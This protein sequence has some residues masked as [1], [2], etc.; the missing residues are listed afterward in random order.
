MCPLTVANILS[1]STYPSRIRIAIVQQNSPS[2][3]DVDCSLP[4]STTC[5][6]SP[7]HVLCRHAHQVDL[8]PMDASTA[9]GPV[10]ARAVGSRLYHGEAYA[11]Q[12][13]AHLEFVEGWDEDI[14]KQHEK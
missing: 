8:Y 6:S 7:S 13:D 1:M 12:V 14:V 11:M 4:P 3:S 9:T 10:L 5:S 2:G